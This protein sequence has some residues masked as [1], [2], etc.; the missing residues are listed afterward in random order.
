MPRTETK[1]TLILDVIGSSNHVPRMTF[2]HFII[3]DIEPLHA[4]RIKSRK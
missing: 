3:A 4:L 1:H 2:G